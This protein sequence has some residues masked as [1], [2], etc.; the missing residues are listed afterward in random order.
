[1]LF[2]LENIQSVLR[3]FATD[4][5]WD[6]FH[7]P[8]NLSTALM[9]EAAELAEIF[10]WDT[11]PESAKPTVVDRDRAADEIADVLIYLVR[12]A[13]VLEIALYPAVLRKIEKNAEK[14]PVYQERLL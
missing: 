7:T 8:K 12:I 5:D 6:R 1:M 2:D 11:G 13:D 9:V 10:Q 3:K 14:H 4:R